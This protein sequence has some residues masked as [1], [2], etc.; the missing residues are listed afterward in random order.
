[1]NIFKNQNIFKKIII[2]FLS[3][4]LLSF[5]QP[6]IT[7]AKSDDGGIGGKLLDPIM[8]MFVGLSDGA[9]TLLQKVIL[10]T[11][12][13]MIEINTSAKGIAKILGWVVAITI[14][15]A[16]VIAVVASGGTALVIAGSVLTVIKSGVI[17][18]V[19]TFCVSSYVANAAL[20]E[21]FV[22]PQIKLSP[23]E[24]FANQIPVFDVDFFNP[25]KDI[26]SVETESEVQTGI[27]AEDFQGIL[28]N[29]RNI[30]NC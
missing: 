14:I 23:Y 20:P 19:L 30:F 27:K 13:S 4:L 9:I 28:N 17:A 5:C 2:I 26:D 29:L 6:K 22:L 16:G 25:S 24:I 1:M 15:V 3:I 18:G 12:G 11:D 21:D 10:H 8:S 7:E